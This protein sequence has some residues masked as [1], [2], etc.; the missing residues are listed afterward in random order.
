MICRR[1]RTPARLPL[2]RLDATPA[3]TQSS[4][5]AVRVSLMVDGQD[6]VSWERWVELARAV[7]ESGLEGLFCS[8]HYL[9][10]RGDPREG[11]LDVWSVL[12]ALAARTRRIR[13]GTMVSP[14]TFRPASVLAKA[15]V[16]VDHVSEGR[17]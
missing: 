1:D 10:L 11:S 4:G 6:G 15:A 9:A 7:E 8:D 13:L 12:A 16:T 3:R 5:G 2:P 17:A 14:V